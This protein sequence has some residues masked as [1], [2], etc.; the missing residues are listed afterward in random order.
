VY[1]APGS[2]QHTLLSC[3]MVPSTRYGALQGTGLTDCDWT[4]QGHSLPAGHVLG[5]YTGTLKTCEQTNRDAGQHEF[6]SLAYDKLVDVALPNAKGN[7]LG[8]LSGAL[9]FAQ[10][11]LDSVVSCSSTV[12]SFFH[13]AM[14]ARHPSGYFFP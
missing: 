9:P 12:R 11:T 8:S 5:E 7:L 10:V 4:E 6:G 1:L 14:M 13:I 3:H 2:V